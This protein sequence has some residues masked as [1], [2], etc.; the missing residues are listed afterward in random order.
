MYQA[1]IAAI[2]AVV[3]TTATPP[4]ATP[5]PGIGPKP[6][7]KS[8]DSGISKAT[9]RQTTIDGNSILPVPR[10]T[11]ASAFISHT[12]TLPVKTT[13]EYCIA[14]SSEPPLPPIA[15]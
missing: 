10:M 7:M 1:R 5:S 8:G 2:I 6:K 9:P 11:L 4:P 3:A 13:F 14:A 15:A 12:R